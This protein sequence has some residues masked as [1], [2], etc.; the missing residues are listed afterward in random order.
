[1]HPFALRAEYVQQLH[2]PPPVAGDRVG[3]AGVEL[4]RL[5]S[6]ER[7]IGVAEHEAELPGDDV[8]PFVA[9][10]DLLF[11]VSWRVRVRRDDLLEHVEPARVA[12]EGEA[13]DAAA[14]G[15]AGVD[16]WVA[17]GRGADQLVQ[18]DVVRL[19]EGQEQF[20]GGPPLPGF[21][22]RQGADGDPGG[23]G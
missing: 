4:G 15:R 20:E 10:M 9:F 19:R 23:F 14:L 6:G 3:D 8:D 18:R 7:E 12:G 17:G 22:S 1:V 5:A 16:A 2:G 13:G 21:Q 11:G